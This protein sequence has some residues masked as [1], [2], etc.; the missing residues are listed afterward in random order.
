LIESI[1]NAK[2]EEDIWGLIENI[3]DPAILAHA[4]SHIDSLTAKT[5]KNELF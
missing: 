5:E 1:N 2:T 3:K 4:K